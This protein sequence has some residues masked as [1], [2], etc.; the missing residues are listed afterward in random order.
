MPER[1][2]VLRALRRRRQVAIAMED[3]L[4]GPA[5]PLDTAL[6][7]L[8]G[9]D[10]IL[11]VLG[12]EAGSLLSDGSGRT[13][14]R[15]E[16]DEATKLGRDVLVF[17]RVD[18]NDR[19]TN[20][21]TVDAKRRALEDFKAEVGVSH[22]W[23]KFATPD[24][25]ALAAVE[26]LLAWDEQ[27]RPGARKTFASAS[28]YFAKN[29]PPFLSPILDLSTTLVGRQNEIADL[30]EFL[31]DGKQ[32]VGV[33][34]GRGGVGKSKLL[35]D[36]IGTITGWD[37]VVLKYSP[38]WYQDSDKEIP[39]GPSVIIIDDV[40]RPEIAESIRQTVQLFAARRGRQPLKLL[41]STRPGL[42]SNLLRGLR[43]EIAESEIKDFPELT[44]LTESQ[45]EE[46]A[47]S[48]L[49]ASHATYAKSLAQI[50]GNSPLVI[51]AGGRLLAA[52]KVE[53]G[54]LTDDAEFRAAVFDRFIDELEL[55][56]PQFA[57]N[58]P[59]PL[60]DLIA[61]LGP[62]NVQSEEFLKGAEEF[63]RA[64]RDQILRT[65]DVL[66]TRGI[67]SGPNEA[68]RILPD[69]LSDFILEKCCIS[70]RVSTGYADRVYQIF[71]GFFFKALMRNLAEL[72]WRV[73]QGQY[74][75]SLLDGIWQNIEQNFL[76]ESAYGR[77]KLLE[78][79]FPAAFF[80]PEEVLRLIG[81]ARSNP[82]SHEET[83]PHLRLRDAQDYVL[84]VVPR[85][86][87]ATAH[88]I[89]TF[90]RSVDILWSLSHEENDTEN[91]DRTARNTLK[92]L[93]SYQLNGWAAFN[94]AVLLQCVRLCR[95]PGAFDSSFTPI[96]VFDQI[97]EREGEFT[98][99]D[100][101]TFRF[102]GF[103]LNYAAVEHLRKN[104]I[105]FLE[106]LLT[107]GDDRIA[108]RAI[109]S[110]DSILHNYL[111][112]VGRVPSQDELDWQ[113]AERLICLDVLKRRLQRPFV[114]LPIRSEIYDAVRSATGFNYTEPVRDACLALLPQ[115]E[116]DP[117]LVVFDALSR[118]EGDLPLTDRD[119]PADSWMQQYGALIDEAHRALSTLDE[120]ARSAKLVD[121]V[122]VAHAAR[123]ET[124]GFSA[125]VHSF[126]R[127]GA[128][129]TTLADQLIVDEQGAELIRELATTL[130]ALHSYAPQNFHQRATNILL[131]GVGYLILA[132]STALRVY[133]ENATH[134]DA[135]LIREF[136]GVPNSSVKRNALEAIAYMGKCHAVLRDLLEAA[137]SVEVGSDANVAD[138][139]ADAFGS[140]GIPVSL[141]TSEEMG[142]LL[143]KFLPIEDFDSHQGSIP[144]F[145]GTLVGRYP[146]EVL[147][148][149]LKR[150]ALEEQ[151]R[152]QHDW[153]FRALGIS[154]HAVSFGSVPSERKPD[155]LRM[156]MSRFL[157]SHHSDESYAQLFWSIDPLWEYSFDVVLDA[158]GNATP[159][160]VSKIELL[161]HRNPRGWIQASTELAKRISNLP[162]E[163]TIVPLLKRMI[164]DTEARQRHATE[165]PADD[166]P[167]EWG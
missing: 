53:L 133:T 150:L 126:S 94:F 152:A 18:D 130:D 31:A 119:N 145:L 88:Y 3:F 111:N 109:H 135:R 123:V 96:D 117:D 104:A 65:V 137:L 110:L 103:G 46:L 40:H 62:V 29:A 35:H 106:Y 49:G 143:G 23:E 87:E 77:R 166:L 125:I 151:R 14:T 161:L 149:L 61:A 2:A 146:E 101:S 32:F 158:L 76:A 60:L 156:C 134:E 59:R 113:D 80:Q 55:E 167:I 154:H 99:S 115:L 121:F 11:L 124:R 50:A 95:K 45:A 97:L 71:G 112:R 52:G 16:Y 83:S 27:G 148:L 164:A 72:D 33:L 122:K 141:L 90:E 144:R 140:Y 114:S 68:V 8:R 157:L 20:N 105:D 128:F 89:P 19:W 85:L 43:R 91:S 153:T 34:G 42:T 48:V 24:A 118:R 56:G 6:A 57:I 70:R 10:L 129:V 107:E 4:A 13:Y 160:N 1:E 44:E 41:F 5:P 82:A 120:Q 66:A 139:L 136:L 58:P 37:V 79:L 21:E 92:R 138:A 28:Q 9:S 47:R 39:A 36:W 159:D 63:L 12:F 30:N 69:V 25:L 86:L 51:V 131:S 84:S 15:A 132:A 100:G 155:L 73:G 165:G 102:G 98:E 74:G 22:T 93:A 162:A 147:N 163:S 127:D 7:E 81:I 64:T 67:L 75:L 142:I 38:L 54:R 26:S 78:D 108:I 17:L 116:R